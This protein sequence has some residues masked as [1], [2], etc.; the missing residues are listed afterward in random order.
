MVEVF[1][2]SSPA[3]R[4][5]FWEEL[6]EK[7]GDDLS[8]VLYFTPS[9]RK[10]RWLHRELS[11]LLFSKGKR[12]F[13][14]PRFTTVEGYVKEFT[15]IQPVG[16]EQRRLRLIKII[17]S[18]R[19]SFRKGF[20]NAVSDFIKTAKIYL[21]GRSP[22]EVVETFIADI[23]EE[24]S[25]YEYA[26]WTGGR[27]YFISK[28]RE[29]LEIWQEYEEE[30]SSQ[31]L[32]DEEALIWDFVSK[33]EGEK[34]DLLVLDGFFDV[35]PLERAFFKKIISSS[36]S[37]RIFIRDSSDP[38]TSDFRNWL[39]EEFGFEEIVH[40]EGRENTIFVASFSKRSDE[41][42]AIAKKIKSLA[43]QEGV[44][45]HKIA[46]VF[47]ALDKYHSIV[48][49]EFD[50]QGIEHNLVYGSKLASSASFKTL[51]NFL[52]VVVEDYPLKRVALL[53]GSRFFSLY[54]PEISSLIEE[55][56]RDTEV[57]GGRA[58]I[59]RALEEWDNPE[60]EKLRS[61]FL[62]FFRLS[63]PFEENTFRGKVLD[64]LNRE[65]FERI[66]ASMKEDYAAK[67][68]YQA[69]K[70]LAELIF[71]M[72]DTLP[73]LD[74]RTFRNILVSEGERRNFWV[75]GEEERGV[76]VLGLLEARGI[77]F[78]VVFFGGLV[79]K[80]FPPP[81]KKELFLSERI[82]EKHRLPSQEK[83]YYIAEVIFKEYTS[84]PKVCFLSHP[85]MERD[86]P[87]LESVFLQD[88][89][90]AASWQEEPFISSWVEK[91]IH[92]PKDFLL[93]DPA[94]VPWQPPS[95]VTAT[96]I[97]V[98]IKC[99]YQFY[100]MKIAGLKISE[101]I[102]SWGL[103][104][105]KIMELSVNALR[106]K[107]NIKETILRNA[108]KVF[109]RITDIE[110]WRLESIA[111]GI[112]EVERNDLR[113]S[114]PVEV[115]RELEFEIDGLKI[116]GRIDRVDEASDGYVIFD[117]KTSNPGKSYQLHLYA[118]GYQQQTGRKVSRAYFYLL[119]DAYQT[120]L[121]GRVGGRS[122]TSMEDAM[123][124]VVKAIEGIKKGDF[125]PVKSNSCYGC[126]FKDICLEKYGKK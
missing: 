62:S 118:Y 14:P 113:D 16:D 99:P 78:D 119:Q 92:S 103:K 59:I 83:N 49:R 76:Q 13:I 74:L 9:S 106:Q 114:R 58:N 34:P 84:R 108:E 18:K 38:L 55:F 6:L 37:V 115:E 73:F 51:V 69:L 35:P 82:K 53:F 29:I 100:L 27:E 19:K 26:L 7:R 54:N 41:V 111:E 123:K 2:F 52:D 91:H 10:A 25:Q 90:Q 68:E 12:V 80:D 89:K 11:Q 77:D 21:P 122:K 45:L 112:E 105:H 40:Q 109:G 102:T 97:D 32:Y 63:T 56:Q 44:P 116:R 67:R 64:V 110:R 66:F 75:E 101:E 1:P 86:E 33:E 72:E 95:Y 20:V 104:L 65:E 124:E 24:L 3:F 23:E 30:L 31:G 70:R 71:E 120:E 87:L 121:R 96:D 17:L 94:P 117:Y 61:A 36:S 57:R 5:S 48:K 47:P 15:G 98:Y 88:V 28:L 85:L 22:A 42:R 8:G 50:A 93:L 125:K 126:P 81:V 60:K 4:A 107:R 46:V 39:R 43:A 79:E